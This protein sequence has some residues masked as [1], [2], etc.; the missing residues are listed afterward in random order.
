MTHAHQPRRSPD[1]RGGQW[2]ADLLQA[3]QLRIDAARSALWDAHGA[4]IRLPRGS[5]PAIAV[6]AVSLEAM[7][8]WRLTQAQDDALLIWETQ[9]RIPF[10]VW[11]RPQTPP[12]E[13]A[14]RPPYNEPWNPR[15]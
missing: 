12:P 3:A 2:P 15:R 1:R 5:D 6:Q 14:R 4:V 7:A 8:A 11:P 10:M 9:T 13:P